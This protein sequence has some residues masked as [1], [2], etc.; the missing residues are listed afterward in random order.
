MVDKQAII[1]NS[2]SAFRPRDGGGASAPGTAPFQFGANW[3]SFLSS[4]DEGR[5]GE[6]ERSLTGM[7]RQGTLEG[8]KFLDAGSGSGLFS[9][10]AR[11]LGAAVHSFDRDPLSVAC[12]EE[13]KRRYF[14]D[15]PG[16][17]IEEGSVLDEPYL[18]SLGSFDVVYSWGVLH[19][20]GDLWGACD[21]VS[22]PLAP[23]GRL[24]VALYNDQGLISRF[25]HEVK[26]AYCS[27][28]VG[29]WGVGAVILPLFAFQAVFIGVVKH[30][31]PAGHFLE[32]RKKR[33]M[34]I[35]HDWVDW[36]GGYPY[37]PAKPDDVFHRFREKGLVLENLVV[38]RRYGCNE[39]VFRLPGGRET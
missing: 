21:K 28:P 19:H 1:M 32:Y 2:P 35:V 9:L 7:L 27:G 38:T 26:R 18:R 11:R 34:S 15:D 6:A 33:G 30:G 4:L 17:R 12:A 36:L 23:G 39:F 20:T 14:P 31:N 37:E 24:F 16:W 8:L 10:A 29:R 3:R 22:I 25:W 5:I 13:L